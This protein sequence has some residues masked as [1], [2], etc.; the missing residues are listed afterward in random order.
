M[1]FFQNW[2]FFHFFCWGIRGQENVF[3]YI[4]ERKNAF[5]GYKNKLLKKSKNWDF[6]KGIVYG[7]CPKLA[8]V[9]IFFYEK[10]WARKLFYDI[11]WLKNA[12]LSYKNKKLKKS[13]NWDF[14][15]F[16]LSG[17]VGQEMCFMI[18]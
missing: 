4:L 11:P 15:T 2:P 6:S 9:S 17:N 3:N 16:F 14:S 18:C 8:I 13:K 1:V 5:L 12:F 7:F 10:I